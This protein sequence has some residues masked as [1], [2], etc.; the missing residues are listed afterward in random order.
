[1]LPFGFGLL[2]WKVSWSSPLALWRSI[3]SSGKT[4]ISYMNINLKPYPMK[5][6]I[7]SILAL[8]LMFSCTAPEE[9]AG[10][11]ITIITGEVTGFSEVSEHDMVNIKFSDP[12]SG[13]QVISTT[14][15]S[16]VT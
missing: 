8:I 7:L 2:T 6:P 3:F 12:V 4:I 9:K 1:M 5:R 11:A 10:E 16:S 15:D 14:V 13:D